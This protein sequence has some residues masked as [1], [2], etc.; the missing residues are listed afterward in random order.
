MVVGLKFG[1]MPTLITY[2]QLWRLSLAGMT[3]DNQCRRE[4]RGNEKKFL[5]EPLDGRHPNIPGPRR[6]GEAV[7]H[8]VENPRADLSSTAYNPSACPLIHF[9]SLFLFSFSPLVEVLEVRPVVP[10]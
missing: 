1:L 5:K 9:V 10:L 3:R 4:D 2:T 6:S 7:S 8:L